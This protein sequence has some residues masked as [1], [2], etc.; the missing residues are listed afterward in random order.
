MTD[1]TVS[2][3]LPCFNQ[4]WFLPR[5]LRSVA[6][7]TYRDFELILVDDGSD[8]PLNFDGVFSVM[9]D[10]TG[11]G[12]SP[13]PRTPRVTCLRRDTPG[14]SAAKPINLG[15]QHALGEWVTW[16]SADNLMS[17]TW[18]ASLMREVGRGAE[19]A[20]SVLSQ[21]E[22][23]PVGAVYSGFTYLPIPRA[24]IER[25]PDDELQVCARVGCRYIAP[26]V[27]TWRGQINDPDCRYGPAF[28]I[29]RDVWAAAGEHDGLGSHDLSH[30]LRVEEACEKMELAIVPVNASLCLYLAHDERCATVA[31]EK[32]DQH[33]QLAAARKRRGLA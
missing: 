29:R 3:I 27:P 31:P 28:M 24:E 18:L 8:P 32:R 22:V 19:F 33:L 4:G 20:A 9:Y 7:Q 1:P 25:R 21:R 16:I 17:P 5:A 13:L 10:G 30:W 6:A 14:G 11:S 26:Q 12:A 2:I 23:R 15:F